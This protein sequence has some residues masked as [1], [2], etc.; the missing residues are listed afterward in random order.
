MSVIDVTDLLRDL[1]EDAPCGPDLEYSA[2]FLELSRLIQG[3]PD[4]QYGNMHRPA[5]EP[6]W[7]AVKATTLRLLA[8]SRDLRLAVY[9]TCASVPLD[10]FAG[11]EDGLA[12]IEGL[13]ERHWDHV[14]PQLDP[15][16][17]DDPTARINTLIALVERDGL[18]RQASLASL[19]DVPMHGRVCLRDIDEAE[20]EWSQQADE[21]VH[22]NVVIDAAFKAVAFDELKDTAAVLMRARG[23]MGRIETLLTERV[24]HTKAVRFDALSQLLRRAESVVM[25]RLRQHPQWNVEIDAQGYERTGGGDAAHPASRTFHEIAHRD[26]VVRLLDL[27]CE[28]YAREN[29][30]S[31]VPLF[32]QRAKRLV[33]MN[34]IEILNDL[35]PQS[36]SEINYLAGT[37]RH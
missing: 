32:L 37:G 19:V 5:Q 30:A 13:L 25:V 10:G 27:I 29:P 6:D 2:D 22:D 20:G 4:I 15:D 18:I 9:L 28:Y 11:L 35:S 21:A 26:D 7:A 23:R 33:D 14:H 24:G 34:F 8:Q 3:T 36:L 12:L 17:A 16:D 31:P 1:S